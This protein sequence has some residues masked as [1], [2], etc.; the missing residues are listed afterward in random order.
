MSV[1]D[2]IGLKTVQAV[3]EE[4]LPKVVTSGKELI[5]A[6]HTAAVDLLQNHLDGTRLKGTIT[7]DVDLALHTPQLGEEQ[8]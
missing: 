5:V 4:T 6:L 2:K 1:G 8:K 7:I 3:T